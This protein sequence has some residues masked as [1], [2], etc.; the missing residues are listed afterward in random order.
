MWF[1]VVAALIFIPINEADVVV[2]VPI[3]V[4]IFL[5]VFEVQT[6]PA[7]AVCIPITKDEVPVA[8]SWIEFATVPPILFE[9]AV[10]VAAAT[11]LHLNPKTWKIPEAPKLVTDI[12]PILLLFAVH[13]PEL[14]L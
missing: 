12:P 6:A 13:D 9:V 3:F 2:P 11:V 4:V 7:F 1:D 10:N 5:M 8:F 14:K